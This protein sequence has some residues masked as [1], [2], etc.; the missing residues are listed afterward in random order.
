MTVATHPSEDYIDFTTQADWE[1][2]LAGHHQLDGAWL[3]IA[4]KDSGKMSI[5]IPE[6]LDVALCY[7][8]I[9]GQRKGYDGSYYLQRYSP[10]RARSSWSQI[11]VEK[12]EVLIA[13]GR[14]QAPGYAEIAA[15]KADGRWAVAYE[16]QATAPVPADLLAA[17]EHS[18]LAKQAFNKLEKGGK[19]AV[20]LPILKAT[21][22][23]SR[24]LQIQKAITKLETTA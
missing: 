20:F 5:T 14:M 13:A 23:K 15:A 21:T 22:P 19:Y 1:A 3:R 18:S 9:D 6:A 8:W 24:E 7:G 16:S 12:A 2:W 17:L 11:N 10:R 4:K